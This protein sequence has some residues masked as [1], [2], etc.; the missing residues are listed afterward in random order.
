MNEM[1]SAMGEYQREE[2]REYFMSYHAGVARTGVSAA[3]APKP[4]TALPP[5]VVKGFDR[6]IMT[7]VRTTRNVCFK[8]K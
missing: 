8:K 4:L 5:E 7:K 3:A 2:Y 6:A 1:W